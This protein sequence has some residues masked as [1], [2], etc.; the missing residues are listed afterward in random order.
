MKN[1][2]PLERNTLTIYIHIEE[3]TFLKQLQN[4]INIFIRG[5]QTHII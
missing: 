4:Y 3:E 1:T 2:L 5:K